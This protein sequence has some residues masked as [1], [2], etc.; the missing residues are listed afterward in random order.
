M[1][2]KEM[3]RVQDETLLKLAD[4]LDALAQEIEEDWVSVLLR[5]GTRARIK[6]FYEVAAMCR[7][8]VERRT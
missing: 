4:Q 1:T 3:R 8:A 7:R 2:V 6:A 5:S